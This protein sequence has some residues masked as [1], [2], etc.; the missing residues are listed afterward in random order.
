MGLKED[1]EVLRRLSEEGPWRSETAQLKHL[2]EEVEAALAV[3]V[4]RELVLEVLHKQGFKF[5]MR[6]FETALYR[7]RKRKKAST[8]PQ[9][10]SLEQL[11]AAASKLAPGAAPKA[12]TKPAPAAQTQKEPLTAE[13][14][15]ELREYKEYEKTLSHLSIVQR[16]KKLSDFLEKQNENKMSLSTRRWLERNENKKG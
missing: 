12:E 13:E 16:A 7:L 5:S 1:K 8:S 11:S 15:R 14:E 9:A 4:K 3:G 6:G 2:L 10:K